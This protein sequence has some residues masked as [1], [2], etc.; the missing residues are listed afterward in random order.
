MITVQKF[1]FNP[2]EENT[3]LVYDE[4]REA[5]LIDCGCMYKE[6]EQ[7]L[8][9]FVAQHDLAIK[10]LLNTHLHYDHAS[11]NAFAAKTWGIKPEASEA[12]ERL[13]PTIQEQARRFG[14]PMQVEIAPIGH[15]LEDNEIISVGNFE[16][17]TL[18]VPGHSPGGL[19]FYC[20]A[21]GFLICGDVLFYR[22][23]GRSD[24]FG[25]DEDT[26][27]NSI[28]KRLLTLPGD[29]IVYCG[30]GPETTIRDEKEYNPYINHKLR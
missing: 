6:E 15:Y 10:R 13:M 24:L 7:E 8:S 27:I 29:T 4:T 18:F 22:S 23:I 11:G 3:Y 5:V 30:H 21:G 16:L 26:L 14:F 28:R 17:K 25:G 12:D 1:T 20:E 19:A 2:I 9:G